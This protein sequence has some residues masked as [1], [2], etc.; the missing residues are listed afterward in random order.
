[1]PSDVGYVYLLWYDGSVLGVYGTSDRAQEQYSILAENSM[2]RHPLPV[3][4][5]IERRRVG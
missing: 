4:M 2:N 3:P 1:M 5:R